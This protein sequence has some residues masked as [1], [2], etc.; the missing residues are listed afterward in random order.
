[1]ATVVFIIKNLYVT[2][3]KSGGKTRPKE[4]CK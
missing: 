1:L 4:S 2:A 3:S